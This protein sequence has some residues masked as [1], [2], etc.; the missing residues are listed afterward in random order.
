MIFL[1][2][3]TNIDTSMRPYENS[4]GVLSMANKYIGYFTGSPIL[5][6]LNNRSHLVLVPVTEK[7]ALTCFSLSDRMAVLPA[8]GTISCPTSFFLQ[9]VKSALKKMP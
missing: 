4:R 9:C 1:S 5:T 6:T 8:M 2:L 7:P 3:Y